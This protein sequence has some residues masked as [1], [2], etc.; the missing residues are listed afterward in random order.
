ME[1][2]TLREAQIVEVARQSWAADLDSPADSGRG[3]TC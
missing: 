3:A 1:L 2:V